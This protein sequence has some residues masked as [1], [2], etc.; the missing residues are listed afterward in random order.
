MSD[1]FRKQETLEQLDALGI[2][3]GATETHSSGAQ[4]SFDL[5]PP[6]TDDELEPYRTHES[7]DQAW[8]I[9][10]PKA[11]GCLL[12][13]VVN[14]GFWGLVAWTVARLLRG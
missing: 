10:W 12:F 3:F 8:E 9:D 11:A 1:D 4:Y 6:G 14:A 2:R 13:A 5:R 7:A